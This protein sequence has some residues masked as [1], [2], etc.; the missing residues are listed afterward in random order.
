M[1]SPWQNTNALGTQE[2]HRMAVETSTQLDKVANS[3]YAVETL[4]QF[5]TG[6]TLMHA[7][8]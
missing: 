4:E 5:R 7:L 8:A 3:Y 1:V 2:H 6:V